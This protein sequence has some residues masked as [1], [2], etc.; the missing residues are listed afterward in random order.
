M[1]QHICL[2]TY[3]CTMKESPLHI[4]L[5]Q[6]KFESEI[7]QAMLSIV[8]AADIIKRKQFKVCESKKLTHSQ[9]NIL[10]ILKGNPEG[11]CRKEIMERMLEK[12]PD[13][14]RLIDGL[15]AY[16]L[17]ERIISKQDKRMSLTRITEKGIALL[18]DL[19]EPMQSFAKE[20]N[21]MYSKTDVKNISELC[22][23]IISV[24]LHN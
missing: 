12:A 24:E 19:H 10:R 17:A 14:T 3:I 11:Y 4:R 7:Q 15:V 22:G 20:L 8:V 2:N 5:K 23:R 16:H 6:K 18:Q 9:Y 21:V 1:L 13:A